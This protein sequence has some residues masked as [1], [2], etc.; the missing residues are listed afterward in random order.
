[1]RGLPAIKQ[2]DRQDRYPLPQTEDQLMRLSGFKYFSSLDPFAGYHQVPMSEESVPYTA[3]VT[4]DGQYE[5]LRMPFGLCNAPAVFQRMMNNVLG[6]HRFTKVLCYLDDLLIPATTLEESLAVLRKTLE[7]LKTAGLTLKLS[8]CYFLRTTI[9][10]LGYV[11]SEAGVQP[12]NL[13]IDAVDNFPTPQNVHQ[14]RQFLGLT[15][16]FRKFIE[17]YAITA[18][19]LTML[20]HKGAEWVCGAAQEEAFSTVK[21]RLVAKPILA[22]FEPELE[23]R[24]YIDASR[25][26][27]AGILV[28]VK[29]GKEFV[30]SY[31]S[32]H[33]TSADQ[34]YHSFELETLAIVASVRGSD[35]FCG[36]GRSRFIR[37]AR[38]Y[39]APS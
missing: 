10:Y 4:Q 7:M 20:L 16:Y 35:S 30:V 8:K 32:R 25:I 15:G 1:M 36:E 11:I 34:N 38:L 2:Y 33:T 17:K 28:Q 14:V 29:D 3:F 6:Q 37:I 13:K 31:F 39:A 21:Q 26:G 19:P 9:E 27:L 24:L 18:K 23:T 5:S 22:L 12:S